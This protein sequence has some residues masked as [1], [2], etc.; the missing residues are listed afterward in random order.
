M[1]KKEKRKKKEERNL[2]TITTI[3]PS[4]PRPP[5]KPFDMVLLNSFNTEF[6]FFT[7]NDIM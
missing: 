7:I 1:N 6:F 3:V 5:P 4:L 2:D